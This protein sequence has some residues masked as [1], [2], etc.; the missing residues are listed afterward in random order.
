MGQQSSVHLVCL[1]WNLRL[2]KR[3]YGGK[4]VPRYRIVEGQQGRENF[5][6]FA[7]H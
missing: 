2:G 3:E 4:L 1:G 7:M 6:T 5:K